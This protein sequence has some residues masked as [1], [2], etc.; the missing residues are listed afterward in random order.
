MTLSSRAELRFA[1]RHAE[2][3][4]AALRPELSEKIPRTK[5]S[6]GREGDG[7]TVRIEADDRNALRAALNSYIR[8]MNVAEETAEEAGT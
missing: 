6:V 5:I 4:A 7:V 2:V 3:V 8:W 1:T